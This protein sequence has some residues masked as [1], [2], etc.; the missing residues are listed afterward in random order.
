[1]VANS[2]VISTLVAMLDVEKVGDRGIEPVVAE[3][4]TWI[5]LM[6]DEVGEVI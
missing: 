5:E 4:G 6:V 1:L 2:E 3:S